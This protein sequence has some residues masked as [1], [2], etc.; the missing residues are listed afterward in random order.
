M[1]EIR[2]WVRAGVGSAII[3]C[4]LCACSTSPRPQN[5]QATATVESAPSASA[6]AT[7]S[8]PIGPVAPTGLDTVSSDDLFIAGLQSGG[9][10]YTDPET[11][12][13]LGQGICSELSAGNPLIAEVDAVTTGS[14]GKWNTDAAGAIVGT[15]IGAYCPQ[16]KSLLPN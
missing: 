5:I 7:P 16:F 12:K 6:D 3:V 1:I 8:A 11:M 10:E 13:A 2:A 14:K 4:A 15:A 9:V